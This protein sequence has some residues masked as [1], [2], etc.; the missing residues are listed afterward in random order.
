ML[1]ND[2]CR[3]LNSIDLHSYGFG[4]SA[5]RSTEDK[6]LYDALAKFADDNEAGSVELATP[7]SQDS[8]WVAVIFTSKKIGRA[9]V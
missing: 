6:A 5:L 4:R 8:E 7:T 2:I 9:H 1:A 3:L